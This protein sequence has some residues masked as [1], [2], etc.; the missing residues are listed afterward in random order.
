[1]ATVDGA[2]GVIPPNATLVFD[3]ELLNVIDPPARFA[4][5][6]A[7]LGRAALPV[8]TSQTSRSGALD[9]TATGVADRRLSPHRGAVH[10]P[11]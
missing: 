3:V 11:G 6:R 10:H 1:L 2:G 5:R 8:D 4:L 7:S 9:A